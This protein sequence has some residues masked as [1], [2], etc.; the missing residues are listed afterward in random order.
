MQKKFQI[1]YIIKKI[2]VNKNKIIKNQRI[3]TIYQ[4]IIKNKN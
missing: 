2:I 3:K 4:K 1:E